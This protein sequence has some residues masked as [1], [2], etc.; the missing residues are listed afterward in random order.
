M[1]DTKG[2]HHLVADEVAVTAD[3]IV[4]DEIDPE[5][6]DDPE[7][8]IVEEVDH[9]ADQTDEAVA[10]IEAEKE[11]VDPIVGQIVTDQTA[12]AVTTNQQANQDPA[13]D[14]DPHPDRKLPNC[15][16]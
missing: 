6:E 4:V 11:E 8:M 16:F 15:P 12:V 10:V 7:A 5:N 3:V 13:Q 9:V 14:P 1:L 2:Q